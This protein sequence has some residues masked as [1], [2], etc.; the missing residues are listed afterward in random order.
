MSG[1][2]K[3]R[4]VRA[5]SPEPA[6]AKNPVRAKSARQPLKEP[7]KDTKKET[8][9]ATDEYNPKKT[10]EHKQ[11]KRT[12]EE[13]APVPQKCVEVKTGSRMVKKGYS[14]DS[15]PNK[16]LFTTI[17]QLKIKKK[18]KSESASIVNDTVK[19]IMDHMKKCTECFKDVNELRTGSYYE[20]LKISNPDEFDVMLTVPV[21]RVDIRPFG[22]VGAF[23]SVAFKR[24]KHSLDR[25]L[26]EDSTISAS[27]MLTEFR[28]EVKKCVKILKGV[29]L[30]KKKKGCP[31][32][33]LL[34]NGTGTVP[35]SLDIV[36]GLE[37]R[38]SW[39]TLTQGGID[40]IDIWL[41]TKVKKEQ[42]LK[43]YY[44]VPKY[45]GKGTV[46][47]D[48]V[49]ARD[50]WRISFSHVEKSILTN[51]GSQK[52]CCEASGT[53]CCRKLCLKLLKHLLDLLKAENPSLSK[54]CSYHAKTTL[55]HACCSRTQ[56]SDWEAAQLGL[57][58]QQLLEDFEGHLKD[59]M[60]PNFFIPKHNLLGSGHD[61][62]S[63]QFLA[64]RIEEERN[65]GFP[66]FRK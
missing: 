17:E 10:K 47:R 20:N 63:C 8:H 23:Y 6:H 29:V 38:S 42:K 62:R 4:S 39:P 31:A 46:E 27:G 45:E 55:L 3:P 21:E 65:N 7:V 16:I 52:T 58:F 44:L 53:R 9:Q 57:C 30:D 66:I 41:G 14:V 32:V 43:G 37:V 13:K 25:F 15:N 60:L 48:G 54:F 36:L 19:H 35:I 49:C 50:A 24:G 61:R 12:T 40:K 59:G 33:T 51:H 5:K 22:D 64:R 1:R 2:G 11:P 18:Q 26:C 28:N 34:I 56:D